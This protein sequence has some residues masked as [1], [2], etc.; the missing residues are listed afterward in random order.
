MLYYMFV[1]IYIYICP[2]HLKS[3]IE[4]LESRTP[5]RE[6]GRAA[7]RLK[8]GNG[9]DETRGELGFILVLWD[10]GLCC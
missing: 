10:S 3:G 2:L 1:Y 8:Q 5:H 7:L 6:A 4:Y 9:E